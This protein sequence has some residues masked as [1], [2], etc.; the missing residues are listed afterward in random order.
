ML[1]KEINKKLFINLKQYTNSKSLK[2]LSVKL[3][4][5]YNTLKGWAR[6]EQTLPEYLLTNFP[7][8]EA[9]LY[10]NSGIL[11]NHNWG[12]SKGAMITNQ[13]IKEGNSDA[14]QKR[15]AGIKRW[16]HE[17]KTKSPKEY[18]RLQ[19]Q[20][21]YNLLKFFKTN[22]EIHA[23]SKQTLLKRYGADY[24][25]KLGNKGAEHAE[26]NRLELKVKK[27]NETLK[28]I[29]FEVHKQIN[30]C[31][32]DFVYYKNNKIVALEEVVG[33]K[34]KKSAM[35]Y[36]IARIKRK[37][38]RIKLNVPLLISFE[39][40]NQNWKTPKRM[41]LEIAKYL[42]DTGI[43]PIILNNTKFMDIKH[44]LI[45]NNKTDFIQIDNCLNTELKSNS[46]RSKAN[47]Q[48]ESNKDFIESENIIRD[49]LKEKVK[50]LG[51]KLLKTKYETYFVSDESSED[52]VYFFS[53]KGFK[54]LIGYGFMVKEMINK[55]LKVVGVLLEKDKH[56]TQTDIELANRYVDKMYWCLDEFK[57][58]PWR[59]GI[60]SA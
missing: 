54:E 21:W 3:N 22:K 45:C 2:E 4:I 15:I 8:D 36:D 50:L 58:G 47:A 39:I 12:A 5:N 59:N 19:R 23:K 48:C 41:Q 29:T 52:T 13:K 16:H 46:I 30:G 55:D 44:E 35:Y 24:Y 57:E 51:K 26:L 20:K 25:S 10:I 38:S 6:G 42:L 31:N 34:K 53:K 56:A 1:N 9:E 49:I 28:G 18:S 17:M 33:L 32:I 37:L 14:L 11:L 40:Q 7:K 43:V 60:A 27:Q